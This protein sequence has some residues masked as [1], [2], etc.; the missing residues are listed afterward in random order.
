MSTDPLIQHLD[1]FVG[2][3]RSRT[4][5]PELAADLVQDCLLK[6]FK[7]DHMPEDVEGVVTWFYRILRNA[8]I[9]V[10]R[11]RQT[12]NQVMEKL[13]GEMPEVMTLEDGKQV[14][15]CGMK[16][17]PALP[18]KDAELLR[19]V[20]MGEESIT[21]MAKETGERVNTLNVRLLRARRR[22]RE[23]VER[24]CRTCAQHGCLDCDCP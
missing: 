21:E 9:D 2:F 24:T 13:A 12:Q 5:D 15:G 3:V 19:R 4:G 10:H 7:S 17:M 1:A 18:A 16:L 11:R 14:C 20:D 6:A 23:Q 8:I 22:L